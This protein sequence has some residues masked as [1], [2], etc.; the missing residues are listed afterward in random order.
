MYAKEGGRSGSGGGEGV[1]QGATAT[2]SLARPPPGRT[3]P[4]GECGLRGVGDHPLPPVRP[5]I[6][7]RW[8]TS[9][10]P[11]ERLYSVRSA[12]RAKMAQKR[13]L[14]RE[15]KM[16]CRLPAAGEVAAAHALSPPSPAGWAGD[17]RGPRLGAPAR[18]RRGLG[19]KPLLTAETPLFPSIFPAGITAGKIDGKRRASIEARARPP[20]P[21]RAAGEHT[22]RV[23]RSG[24]RARGAHPHRAR[25]GARA[26]PVR[27]VAPCPRSRYRSGG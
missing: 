7:R 20:R 6:G 5:L 9:R 14:R 24:T 15:G 19:S 27:R 17:G 1:A 4:L 21:A 8:G 10:P 26:S 25:L 22:A 23:G 11:Q 3:A 12:A 13:A 16:R 2:P 18:A